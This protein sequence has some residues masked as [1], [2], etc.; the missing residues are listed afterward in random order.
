MLSTGPAQGVLVGAV[1]EYLVALEAVWQ[2]LER[3]LVDVQDRDL[4]AIGLEQRG[5]LRPEATAT[6]DDYEHA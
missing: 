6:H 5:E 1:A 4:V 3:Q 2:M